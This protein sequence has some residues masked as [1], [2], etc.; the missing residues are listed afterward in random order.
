MTPNIPGADG[1]AKCRDRMATPNSPERCDLLASYSLSYASESGAEGQQ[2]YCSFEVPRAFLQSCRKGA[3][4][5]V[6]ECF[7]I[8]VPNFA[9]KIGPNFPRPFRNCSC[10][11]SWERQSQK[12]REVLNGVGKDGVGVKFPCFE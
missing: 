10:F 5:E 4:R 1:T 11:V 3:E 8:I 9:P 7:K 12:I 6:P 2:L